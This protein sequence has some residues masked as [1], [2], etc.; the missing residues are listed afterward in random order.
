MSELRGSLQSTGVSNDQNSRLLLP[1]LGTSNFQGQNPP[2]ASRTGTTMSDSPCEWSRG[3]SSTPTLFL[4]DAIGRRISAD[5]SA[6][7]AHGN[8]RQNGSPGGELG[9]SL[10]LGIVVSRQISSAPSGFVEE[11][12]A[13][14]TKTPSQLSLTR[15]GKKSATDFPFWEASNVHLCSFRFHANSDRRAS[16]PWYQVAAR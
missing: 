13:W 9:E 7:Q 3:V 2:V 15:G 6:W 5:A 4:I 8:L 16:W 12:A 10:D 14:A 11:A 1:E